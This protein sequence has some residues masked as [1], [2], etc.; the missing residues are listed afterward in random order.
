MQVVL[1]RRDPRSLDE[2]LHASQ[3]LL[4]HRP[5]VVKLVNRMQEHILGKAA[6]VDDECPIHVKLLSSGVRSRR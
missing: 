6:L 2:F 3:R 5:V 4:A 1:L